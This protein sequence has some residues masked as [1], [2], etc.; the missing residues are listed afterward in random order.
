[1]ATLRTYSATVEQFGALMHL[2][3]NETSGTDA[4]DSAGT[5]DGQYQGGVERGATG[6]IGNGAVRLDGANEQIFIETLSGTLTV[7]AFGD[8]LIDGVPAFQPAGQDF[9]SVLETALQAR[10]LNATVLNQAA[11]GERSSAG[12]ARVDEVIDANP[13]VAIVEFGTNDAI[14]TVAAGTV[15]NNLRGIINQLQGADIEVLLTGAFAFYPDRGNGVG[16]GDEAGRDAFEEIFAN[17]AAETGATLLRDADGS[18]QFLGGSREGETITGGVLGDPAL[19]ALVNDEPDGLHPNPAGIQQI[20]PRVVP[21]TI[22]LGAAAG[23]VNEPLLLANG[24]FEI[25]FSP[26]TVTGNRTLF[27]KNADD[28]GTGGHV[29]VLIQDGEILAALGDGSTDRMIQSSNLDLQAGQLTHLVFT[30][31]AAGM[32]L[33]V[34]GQAVTVTGNGLGYTGGLDAGLGNFEPLIVG[35]DAGTAHFQGVI[36]EFAVYDGAL[37]GGEVASLFGAGQGGL[38]LLGTAA[39]DDIF[40]G[41]D[42]EELRGLGGDDTISG[43]G[44]D[45]LLRGSPGNDNIRGDAGNDQIFGD[46]GDD[47][48]MGG[49]GNDQMF[50]RAGIDTMFGGP[51]NDRLEGNAAD[52]QM[53]GGPGEDVLVGGTGND[54]L[55]GGD[56][57]D[58][59]FGQLGEDTMFGGAGNDRLEGNQQR[60][61]LWGG[62]GD[63]QLL[64]N[65]DPDDLRG[66]PGDDLLVGGFGFDTLVGGGGSDTFRMDS[67]DQGIDRILDFQAGLGGDV[68][69]MR[70]L[71]SFQDGDAIGDF[72]QLSVS[73]SDT[74]VAA[75]P[76]GAGSNF[77][78]VFNLV[79]VT[80]LDVNNLLA[81][82]NLQVA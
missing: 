72:V 4:I 63:D 35:S 37:S 51:G 68:L 64:G 76:D 47:A 74:A 65:W 6:A 9:S 13:D 10:G 48:L 36:D 57:D 55:A 8:S 82:G 75:N 12:L 49:E 54:S 18:F 15:E 23:V 22:A 41:A 77:T 24:S 32:Q 31:G 44:G 33:F 2:R 58:R 81:D 66:G 17:L 78:A 1:M 79:G 67:V 16:Y 14:G 60:D 25:W 42:D 30:F 45:D 53:W 11:A 21:Q 39:N 61:L 43:G 3:L 38:T 62:P 19:Q 7:S 26:D 20:V 5:L 52:D 50:G 34:D 70:N 59:L 56:D 40:G 73:G 69:D 29:A 71:L 28:Q 46:L 80:G 27:S